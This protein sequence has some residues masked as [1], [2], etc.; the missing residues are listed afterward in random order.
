MT[1]YL[2]HRAED[3]REQLLLD[4]LTGVARYAQAFADSFGAGALAYQIG[5]AHAPASIR[6]SFSAAF[7][8][9]PCRWIIPPQ[10]RS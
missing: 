3:G 6:T 10:G 5:L 2:G 9:Q 4:H 1:I 7:A 8:A